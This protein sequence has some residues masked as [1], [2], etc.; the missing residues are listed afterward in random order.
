VSKRSI[1]DS[2]LTAISDHLNIAEDVQKS[3]IQRYLQK[4]TTPHP[5]RFSAIDATCRV[6]TR[7][8]DNHFTCIALFFSRFAL[9][10]LIATIFFLR[11]AGRRGDVLGRKRGRTEGKVQRKR[12]ERGESALMLIEERHD[13]IVLPFKRDERG[14]TVSRGR[15]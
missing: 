6:H 13:R 14:D 5:C 3:I 8:P 4:V 12:E 9:F 1:N 10:R 15:I 11:R 2:T 7:D